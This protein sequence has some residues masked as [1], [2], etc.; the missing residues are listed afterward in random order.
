[1]PV[2][3]ALADA[4]TPDDVKEHPLAVLAALKRRAAPNQ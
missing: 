1:M 4:V 2:P 3:R